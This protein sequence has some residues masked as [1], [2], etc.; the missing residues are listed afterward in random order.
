MKIIE[1]GI[2][3]LLAWLPII[4]ATIPEKVDIDEL[5]VRE[6]LDGRS[7]G[8]LIARDEGRDIGMSVWYEDVDALYLWLGVSLEPRTGGMIATLDWLAQQ[9]SYTRWTAKTHR[10]NV[11]ARSLLTRYGLVP[12]REVGGVL[13]LAR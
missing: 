5:E 4:R 11:A 13:H 6:R 10:G 7:Y 2:E 1:A 12:E 3:E 8:V 9:T